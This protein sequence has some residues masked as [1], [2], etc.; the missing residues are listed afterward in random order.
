MT[1]KFYNMIPHTTLK[2]KLQK[3]RCSEN[4]VFRLASILIFLL[5]NFYFKNGLTN[6]IR[7]L[8]D[9]LRYQRVLSKK[10]LIFSSSYFQINSHKLH[11]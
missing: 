11:F 7:S 5:N 8:Y 1:A 2:K 4:V 9:A 6:Y 10:F 3:D